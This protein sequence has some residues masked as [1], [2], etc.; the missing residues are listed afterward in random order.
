MTDYNGWTNYATWRVNLEM[1][2]GLEPDDL[3][4]DA[5]NAYDLGQ[6]FK[7]Y[8]IDMLEAETADRPASSGISLV[9]SYA[10]AFLQDVNWREIAEHMIDAYPDHFEIEETEEA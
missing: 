2:D 7:E 10:M 6:Y 8:C 1:I 3:M 9:L 5:K 4:T